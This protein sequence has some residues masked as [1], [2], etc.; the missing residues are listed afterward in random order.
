MA[1]NL[2]QDRLMELAEAIQDRMYAREEWADLLEAFQQLLPCRGPGIPEIL[3]S[4]GPSADGNFSVEEVVERALVYR[5]PKPELLRREMVELVERI[6]AGAGTEAEQEEWL[7][8]LEANVP[9]PAV[10]DLIFWPERELTAEEI[11]DRAL[12][13][14]S[15]ALPPPGGTE[16]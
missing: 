9:D 14:E 7:E 6:S 2:N 4:L 13:Y 3:G 8:T 16:G 10:S 1:T 12:A 11:V 15:V 5:W